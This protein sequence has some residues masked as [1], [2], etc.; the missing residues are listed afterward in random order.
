MR[1]FTPTVEQRG[2]GLC[3]ERMRRLLYRREEGAC[4][5]YLPIL[6]GGEMGREIKRK[7]LS[8]PAVEESLVLSQRHLP[9]QVFN[10]AQSSAGK[11]V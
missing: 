7:E 4:I 2:T 8:D 9:S 6:L 5:I 10:K 1:A 11:R 3:L